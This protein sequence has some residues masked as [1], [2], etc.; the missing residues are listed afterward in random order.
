ML[1]RS[2]HLVTGAI[3]A[4]QRPSEYIARP[5]GS[6][7]RDCT[8]E[9]TPEPHTYL[10]EHQLPTQF[11]WAD[12][13]GVSMLTRP[14][15][16]H[17]PQ[18]CGS[19]WAHAALS[20][21]GDRIKI[22]KRGR[23][24]EI[25]LAIQ[26]VL[27]CGSMAGSCHGGNQLSV[28]EWVKRNGNI[29]FATSNPYLACSTESTEGWCAHVDTSCKPINIAR[30]CDTFTASGG[31]C[32]ALTHYPNATVAEYGVVATEHKIMAEVSE[33]GPVACS[34]A[35]TDAMDNYEGGILSEGSEYNYL[36]KVV[37]HVVSIVGWG[38]EN[39]VPYWVVRNSWGEEIGRAHV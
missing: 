14:L 9:C 10:A 37:N 31:S 20:A 16:Q 19:C 5:A 12:V 2:L 33:R 18:Y 24:A 39:S 8:G 7:N 23:G 26:H 38:V 4:A 28:Y 32:S 21:L 3:L 1:F 35:A 29:A 15:N 36:N 30:T 34:V 17:I 13:N 6:L 22:A 25:N 27:N 11:S